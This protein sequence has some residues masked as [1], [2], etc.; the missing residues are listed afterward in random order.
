MVE[1]IRAFSNYSG[2][3]VLHL[4]KKDYELESAIVADRKGASFII[5]TGFREISGDR[6]SE[7]EPEPS[8]SRLSRAV[9]LTLFAG[10]REPRTPSRP[11]MLHFF[12]TPQVPQNV[13]TTYNRK[14]RNSGP[15]YGGNQWQPA[16]G[17]W[18]GWQADQP[19]GGDGYWVP[20]SS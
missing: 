18:Q 4:A 16:I 13:V 20:P 8:R 14:T 10:A 7:P 2:K 6:R 9:T 3:M 19:Q 1:R 5:A 11:H 12:L 17:W 15:L